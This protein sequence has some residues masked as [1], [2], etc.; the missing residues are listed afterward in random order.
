MV[1]LAIGCIA[2]TAALAAAFVFLGGGKLRRRPLPPGP[3]PLPLIG[4]VFDIPRSNAWERFIEWKDLYGEVVYI[5]IL[6]RSIVLLNSVKST[7]DLLEKR[8]PSYS[9]RPQ[10]PLIKVGHQ[11]NFGF[12]PYGREWQSL[13]RTFTSQYNSMATLRSFYDAHRASAT[14][15]LLNVLHKPEELSN[16]MRIRGAQVI[17]EVTYGISVQSWDDTLVQTAEAV[18]D[19]VSIALYPS[20]WIINPISILN[21]FPRWLGGGIVAARVRRW[22]ADLENLRNAPF[23]VVK[24][25]LATGTAKPCFTANLLQE[26]ETSS[27]NNMNEGIIRDTAAIAL[28]AAYETTFAAGEVFLLAMLLNEPV[29]GSAQR[30]IDSVVGSDRLPDF[31]DRE[32]L[33]FVTAVMKEVLRW[34]PPAPTGIPHELTH[35]DMYEG[36][37]LPAGSIVMANIWGLLHDPTM[38]PDPFTFDPSRFIR[39]GK[40]DCTK[41]DPSRF[42]FGFGRRACPGRLFTEDSLWL[43]IAQFLAV[44]SISPPSNGGPPPKAA[45][46]SG[47]I[48]RP[49][50][51]K[52]V[53]RPRSQAAQNL[54]TQL[55]QGQ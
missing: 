25:S 7:T 2:S 5:S 36:M 41:N 12:K 14:T 11:W 9:D 53:V 24:K 15:F 43:M 31:I 32:R 17:F 13:R 48:S 28:G 4:N 33:P 19:V 42:V 34:H 22:Q 27:E 1:S 52:H 38:Y 23:E 26:L 45:F 44:Y 55:A 29:Q 16:H 51:F 3:R 30:E 39:D 54:L 47:A 40:L 37:F 49:L 8:A 6:G 18:M 21:S 35:D 50:P 20:M 46:T 10:F